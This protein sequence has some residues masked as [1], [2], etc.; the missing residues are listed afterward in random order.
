MTD[1]L[2]LAEGYTRDWKYPDSI[3]FLARTAGIL[4]PCRRIAMPARMIVRPGTG[5]VRF[6]VSSRGRLLHSKLYLYCGTGRGGP[7]SR[8]VR[9]SGSQSTKERTFGSLDAALAYR[10]DLGISATDGTGDGFFRPSS[11]RCR[12]WQWSRAHKPAGPAHVDG[13]SVPGG[14]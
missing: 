11:L 8:D 4:W 9:R 13:P 7:F 5:A 10:N 12:G 14:P 3:G 2:Q 1:L 6:K